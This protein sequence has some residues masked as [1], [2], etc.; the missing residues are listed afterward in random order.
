MSKSMIQRVAETIVQLDGKSHDWHHYADDAAG[1]IREMHEPTPAMI[2]A[3][4][5]KAGAE[6]WSAMIKEALSVGQSSG[7]FVMDRTRNDTSGE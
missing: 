2:A 4:D 6:A 3:A 1:I 5:G 7:S